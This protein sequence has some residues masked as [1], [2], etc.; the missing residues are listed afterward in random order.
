M[1]PLANWPAFQIEDLAAMT[2]RHARA[3]RTNESLL[4]SFLCHSP[5]F[6]RLS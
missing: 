3:L 6:L 5:L 1:N 4:R 2:H